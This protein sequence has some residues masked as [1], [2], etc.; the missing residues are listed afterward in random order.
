V[1]RGGSWWD[2]DPD[3]LRAA[4]RDW[5]SPDYCDFD[6]GFRLALS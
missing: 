2:D 6:W 1:L 3:L 5:N 4:C